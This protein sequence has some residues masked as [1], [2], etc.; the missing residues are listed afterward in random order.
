MVVNDEKLEGIIPLNELPL[1]TKLLMD[2]HSPKLLGNVPLNLFDCKNL[3]NQFDRGLA[4][5]TAR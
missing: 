3:P 5:L 4:R 1:T 2:V